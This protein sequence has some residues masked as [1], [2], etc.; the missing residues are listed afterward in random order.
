MQPDRFPPTMSPPSSRRVSSRAR[1]WRWKVCRYGIITAI[2]GATRGS[3]IAV[4]GT[5]G[6]ASTTPMSLSHDALTATAEMAL[7]IEA[8]ARREAD[9]V[10]TVGRLDLARRD[11]RHSRHTQFSVDLRAPDDARRAAA[12][13]GSEGEHPFD[14][15]RAGHARDGCENAQGR[16]RLRLRSAHRG[17]RGRSMRSASSRR[18]LPSAHD[19]GHGRARPGGHAV[20]PLQGRNQ[21]QPSGI[22][23]AGEIRIRTRGADPL[24]AE[25]SASLKVPSSGRTG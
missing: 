3:R 6:H 15:R 19:H 4:D 20:R 23:H 17:S 25:I 5:A 18:L 22:N 9:L 1:C 16:E 21:S 13:A 8:R 2:D 10:A 24:H 11:R 14:R 12:L 7:A